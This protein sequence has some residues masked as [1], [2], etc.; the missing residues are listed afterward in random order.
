MINYKGIL[1]FDIDGTLLNSKHQL[2]DRTKKAL[3][4]AYN[5]GYLLALSSGRCI[6]GLKVIRDEIQIPLIQVS[7]NG[8]YV[9]SED[10]K[11]ISE[12]VIEAF[13]IKEIK[14]LIN[15]YNLDLMYFSKNMWAVEK[16]G[17]LYDYEYSVVKADGIIAPIEKYIDAVPIHKML[18]YGNTSNTKAFIKEATTLFPNLN[19]VSSSPFYVEINTST[20]DKGKG[21]LDTSKYYGVDISN[22]YAFGDYD[23]D[24]AAFKAAGK[25]IAMANSSKAI[26]EIA[27][28]VTLSNDE[29]GVA[30]FIENN[31]L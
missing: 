14:K 26:L 4:N 11:L 2:T 12:S 21:I 27:D 15:S 23:N 22:T 13:T 8:A 3:K 30:Y 9:V 24:L 7:I 28:V 16:Y 18:A 25:S 19:I 20:A 29:D 1:F 5:S 17:E 10:N 31:L 6:D